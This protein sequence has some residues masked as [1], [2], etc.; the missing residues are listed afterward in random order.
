MQ[1]IRDY[2]LG[3]FA[4]N[5]LLLMSLM[6]CWL[7]LWFAVFLHSGLEARANEMSK[8]VASSVNLTRT[9]LRF[10]QGTDQSE[11]LAELSRHESL[12]VHVR[13]KNDKVQP[14]PAQQY[15]QRIQTNLH[16]TLGQET[17]IAWEINQRPG[18]WVSFTNKGDH[19]WLAF[20]RQQ[21]NGVS[22]MQ[23]ASWVMGALLLS[24]LGALIIT[25]YVNQPLITLARFAKSISY[26]KFTPPLPETGARE[27]R[28]VNASFN[29]M[30]Q[31]LRQTETA[32]EIVL[33]GLSHDLRTP[34]TR[35]RLEI[36]MSP[37]SEQTRGLVDAD[38]EQVDHS[39][40]KL[41]EYARA[42]DN[43]IQNGQTQTL[44]TINIS[45][46]LNRIITLERERVEQ[47]G[48]NLQARVAD[49]LYA[50]IEPFCLQR[51][52]SNLFE[53][54]RRYGCNERGVPEIFLQLE[55]FDKELILQ[56]SDTGK[57]IAQRDAE[58]LLRPFARGDT[59]S[60]GVSGTGLG[61]AIVER[62]VNQAHGTLRL[63]SGSKGLVVRIILPS[64]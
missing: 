17:V 8:R 9:A 55:R 5:F 37:M 34:L 18:F 49:N 52:I 25:R 6:L 33:A 23:W 63:L 38:L 16:T 47:Q 40:N 4:R 61:L 28:L 36:E 24:L 32:R 53:N 45:I 21:V 35:M 43:R 11:L 20:N 10:A 50:C 48:G 54:I 22:P 30:A 26:G 46:V 62:L 31:A 27:I 58:T 51:I 3:L 14:L 2:S 19:Y 59:S 39:I 15:W 13:L 60:A 42:S 44:P 57:G 1:K 7:G 12:D 64:H 29:R 56:I 41:I